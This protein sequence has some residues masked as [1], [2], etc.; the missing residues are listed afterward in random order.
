MVPLKI[1]VNED[2]PISRRVIGCALE[3]GKA[4]ETA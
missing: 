4:L 3:G 1:K 2:D